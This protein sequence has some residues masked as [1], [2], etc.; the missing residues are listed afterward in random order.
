[1]LNT[2]EIQKQYIQGTPL[3]NYQA[4]LVLKAIRHLQP[5]RHLLNHNCSKNINKLIKA[6]RVMDKYSASYDQL[7]CYPDS[8]IFKNK[9]NIKNQELLFQANKHLS[10]LAISQI[11]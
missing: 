11:K 1:M 5:N 6:N 2:F 4:S 3:K 8:N 9:L 10:E 7:Y